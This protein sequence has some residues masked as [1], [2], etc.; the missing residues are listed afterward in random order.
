MQSTSSLSNLDQSN[1][2]IHNHPVYSRMNRDVLLTHK[3]E[4]FPYRVIF[5]DQDVHNDLHDPLFGVDQ[6]VVLQITN[7]WQRILHTRDFS[8]QVD[9]FTREMDALCNRVFTRDPYW[10]AHI[11]WFLNC[12]GET[13]FLVML[14]EDFRQEIQKKALTLPL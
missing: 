1:H 11:R 4:N 13:V 6:E 10:D 12:K 14:E 7:L 8:S 3:V 5:I 2:T 9:G